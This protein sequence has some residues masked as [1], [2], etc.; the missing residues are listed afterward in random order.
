[1]K[2]LERRLERLE[3]QATAS[4]PAAPDLPDTDEELAAKIIGLAT[5]VLGERVWA[6]LGFEGTP[7]EGEVIARAGVLAALAE[8]L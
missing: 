6:E 7:S 5:R 2:E 3:G 8:R 4:R 1:M